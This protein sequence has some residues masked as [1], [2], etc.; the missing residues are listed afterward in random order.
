[1]KTLFSISRSSENELSSRKSNDPILTK[2][3][4]VLKERDALHEQIKKLQEDIRLIQER[5]NPE[6]DV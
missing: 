6:Y 2:L 4:E 3:H 5:F 1:V